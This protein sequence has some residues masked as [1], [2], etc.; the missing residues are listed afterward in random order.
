LAE[1]IAKTQELGARDVSERLTNIRDIYAGLEAQDY[2][3]DDFG[4]A[5]SAVA[6]LVQQFAGLIGAMQ[7][8]TARRDAE[9][10]PTKRAGE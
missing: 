10:K 2:G 8:E 3:A 1:L 6:G 7:A 5:A 9:R 4:K